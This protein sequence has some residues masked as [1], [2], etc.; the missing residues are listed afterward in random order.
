MYQDLKRFRNGDRELDP[1]EKNIFFDFIFETFH[2]VCRDYKCRRV[3]FCLE[4]YP[5][6][7]SF[8]AAPVFMKRHG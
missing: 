2:R 5:E 4:S 8:W 3:L 6:D 1:D 7:P